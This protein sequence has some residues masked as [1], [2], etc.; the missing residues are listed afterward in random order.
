MPDSKDDGQQTRTGADQTQTTINT[1]RWI[2]FVPSLA[3]A[4][5]PICLFLDEFDPGSGPVR[6]PWRPIPGDSEN[7]HVDGAVG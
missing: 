1:N 3:R 5:E 4:Y 7:A 6:G 2:A